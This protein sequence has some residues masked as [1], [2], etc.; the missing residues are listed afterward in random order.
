MTPRTGHDRRP[1]D[2]ARHGPHLRPDRTRLRPARR[3]LRALLEAP[4]AGELL[5]A[6]A[7]PASSTPASAPAATCR[8]IRPGPE[9]VGID[10]SRQMLDRARE[11]ARELGRPVTLLPMNLLAL[12][13]PDA[14][15][16]TVAVTFVLLC[17][18]DELQAPA[19]RE[20][21]RV[22]RPG[23]RIL[24]L[25]YRLSEQGRACGSGCAAWHRG[26]AGR[27]RPASTPRPS[28]TWTP[29][30]SPRSSSG[31]YMGDGVHDADP[32]TGGTSGRGGAPPPE[33]RWTTGCRPIWRA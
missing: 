19:L 33:R 30:D 5:S 23:G 2:H 4:P 27:S 28:A 21:R 22:T 17:L 7:R 24:L 31:P 15:F 16:D 29:P 11:R 32:R 10:M 6:R 12:D 1:A 20:L 18:P 9:V 13:F 14:S 25:D 26:C 8:S 3:H